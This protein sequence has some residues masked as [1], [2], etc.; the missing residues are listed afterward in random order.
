MREAGCDIGE[1][2]AKIAGCFLGRGARAFDLADIL[3]DFRVST[4][5]VLFDQLGFQF[6]LNSRGIDAKGSLAAAWTAM[7]KA[8]VKRINADDLA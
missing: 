2:F 3:N 7:E 6:G 4:R 8:G 1:L 5:I